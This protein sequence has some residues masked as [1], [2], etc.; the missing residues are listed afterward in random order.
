MA[1]YVPQVPP[2]AS[3]PDMCGGDSKT[4]GDCRKFVCHTML[5]GLDASHWLKWG[6]MVDDAVL[7][8]GTDDAAGARNVAEAARRVAAGGRRLLGQMSSAL[9]ASPKVSTTAATQYNDYTAGGFDPLTVGCANPDSAVGCGGDSGAIIAVV[10]VAALVVI[11]A[12]IGGVWYR[13]RVNNGG[14][15]AGT[16]TPI[17]PGKG[18][19]YDSLTSS[20][21]K[22]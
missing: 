6:S 19:G 1:L 3:F 7:S 21:S 11:A 10:A 2:P 8:K 12:A 20:Y 22:A 17:L 13:R 9:G 18:G 5:N 15:G 14:G 16:S 4:A